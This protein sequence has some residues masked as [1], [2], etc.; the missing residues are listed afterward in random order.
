[1]AF[2][3]KRF[4]FIFLENFPPELVNASSVIKLNVN[5]MFMSTLTARDKNGDAIS[6]TWPTLPG[7]EVTGSNNTRNFKLTLSSTNKVRIFVLP[8]ED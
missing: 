5:E 2:G 3:Y 4:I 8:Y 1:M 6:F 7:L